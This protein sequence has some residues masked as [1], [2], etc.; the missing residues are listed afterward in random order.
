MKDR[1]E[2]EKLIKDLREKISSLKSEQEQLK[3]D[4]ENQENTLGGTGSLL[5][6]FPKNKGKVQIVLF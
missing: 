3:S 2:K 6:V 5:I 4:I 1:A